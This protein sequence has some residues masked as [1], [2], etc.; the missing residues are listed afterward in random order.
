MTKQLIRLNIKPPYSTRPVAN[1][2]HRHICKAAHRHSYGVKL[3][4]R[5]GSGFNTLK[6]ALCYKFIIL[7]KIKA[8]I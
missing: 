2:G 1:T 6:K 4:G 5:K 8:K 3:P 7:L